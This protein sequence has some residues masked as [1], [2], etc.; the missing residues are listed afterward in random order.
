MVIDTLLVT[1]IMMKLRNVIEF[2]GKF[3]EAEY[4]SLLIKDND[5]LKKKYEQIC[6]KIRYKIAN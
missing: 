2:T 3:A 4:I 1:K 6:H 5:M